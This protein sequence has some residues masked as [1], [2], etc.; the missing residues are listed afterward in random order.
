MVPEEMSVAESERL[1]RRLDGFDIPVSTVVVNRV[2]QDLADM[3]GVDAGD[4]WF[5]GPDLEDC[6]FCKRRWEVQRG[7]LGRAQELFRG[8]AVKRVPLFADEVQGESML[9]VV[10][11]CLD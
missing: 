5:V 8:R 3:T 11:A 6:A 10:A 2:M 7:A 1:I 4:E 9:R